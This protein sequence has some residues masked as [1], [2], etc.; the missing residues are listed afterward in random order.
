MANPYRSSWREGNRNPYLQQAPELLQDANHLTTSHSTPVALPINAYQAQLTTDGSHNLSQ[1]ATLPDPATNGIIG[2]RH[3]VQAESIVA[4]ATAATATLTNDGTNVSDSDTVVINGVTYTFQSSLTNSAGHVKI[5]ASAAASMTNLFHAINASGGVSGTDYAAS[6]IT[7]TS[8]VA[9]NPTATTVVLTAIAAGAAANAFATTE[10]SSH[11]A[12][13]GV[14]MSGGI[15]KDSI[16]VA[17]TYISIASGTLDSVTLGA[18]GDWVL[19]EHRGTSWL[20]VGSKSGV[21]ASH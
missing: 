21:V 16:A 7:N 3:V 12:F 10:T 6:C 4:A 5:G 18:T 20:V 14:T 17:T 8:V 19:L 13:G 11:L 9:T 15:D 1:S 2:Q